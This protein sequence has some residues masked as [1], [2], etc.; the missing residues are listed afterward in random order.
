MADWEAVGLSDLDA[1]LYR[2]LL[3]D[4]GIPVRQHSDALEVPL[5]TI[6][7]A[8]GRLA[9]AGLIRSGSED[10]PAPVD[11]RSGVGMLV[12]ERRAALDGVAALTDQLAREYSAGQLL[13]EPTR[14]IEIAVGRE[15]IEARIEDMLRGATEQAVGT[16]TPPYVADGSSQV[17]GAELALLDRGVRFRAIYASEVLDHP[18][19]VARLS[20]MAERGEQARVLPQVP[21]KLL[22]VDG[23]TAIL[24]LAGDNPPDHRPSGQ[25]RAVV[26]TDSV[27]TNA[28]QVLFDQL[29][30]QATPLRL[31]EAADPATELINLLA[32]GMK[33]EAIARQLGISGR[34]LRRRIA[35]VQDQLGAT[36]RFQ[37]GLQAARH[38]WVEEG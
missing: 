18:G 8:V 3:R 36:S 19:W 10:A 37:A 15:A 17:S 12:R 1:R 5:A 22:I 34:T 25:A 21:L 13:A 35:Q 38:G 27:L 26:V 9:A 24:P 30:A 23:T 32:S 31:S 11:P 29:W 4:P 20:S 33:D 6:E 2:Q 16:D 14:L 7:A 28:L